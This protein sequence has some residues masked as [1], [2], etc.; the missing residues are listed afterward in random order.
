M[1]K[2]ENHDFAQIVTTN[3]LGYTESAVKIG[4]VAQSNGRSPITRRLPV[5]GSFIRAVVEDLEELRSPQVEHELRI[6]RKIFRESKGG[7]ILRSKFAEFLAEFDQHSIRP[8]EHVRRLLA[9]ATEDGQP[10]H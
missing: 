5:V 6:E 9:L 2:G 10:R 4:M 7:R 3:T 8:S 1:A